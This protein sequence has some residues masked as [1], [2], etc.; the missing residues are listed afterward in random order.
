[1]LAFLFFGAAKQAHAADLY[2]YSFNSGMNC[3]GEWQLPDSSTGTIKYSTA[4]GDDSNYNPAATHPS[5]TLFSP[6]G[7]SSVT[8]DNI[9]GLMWVTNP[10]DAGMG[11]TYNWQNALAACE[12]TIGGAGTYAT[13][14]DW[15]LPNVR[16][17]MS[18]VDYGVC[19][20][21]H[22]NMTFFFGTS[23]AVYWTSTTYAAGSTGA[24]EVDFSDGSVNYYGK[25]TSQLVRCVRGGS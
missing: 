9:T 14:S 6:V 4:T 20:Q 24:W 12:T 1:M 11:A 18:I 10:S 15:R 2:T 19:S 17:L 16:E 23:A 22:I 21:P 8:V 7:S 5:Y 25:S 13:Y 3:Y